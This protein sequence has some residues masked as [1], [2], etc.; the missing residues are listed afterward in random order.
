MRTF[1]NFEPGEQRSCIGCHEHRTQAPEGRPAWALRRPP[2]KLAAQPGEVA[3]RPLYYP[4]DVQPILDRHCVR[5]HNGKDPKA[6]PDLRGELTTL[7]NRSYESL[8]Q[9]KLVNAIQEW[10]SG[11]YAM[12]NAE[13]VPPYTYGSHRSKLVEVLRKGHYDARLTK[14]E[15]IKL[16]TWIDGGA[17]YYGSYFGR[18]HLKYQGQPDFRPVPTLRSAC[19]L[20]LRSS[21]DETPRGE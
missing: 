13:A 9:G 19:G 15:W 4:T 21:E 17:P 6:A 5:C 1:V 3:P 20:P 14:E 11:T 18:R 8:L 10:N 16:V 12:Q 7:F 2:A